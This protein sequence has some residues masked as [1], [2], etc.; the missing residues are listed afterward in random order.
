FDARLATRANVAYLNDRFG[1]FNHDLELAL[2]A[3][4][5]GEGRVGRLV[6]RA[7]KKSFWDGSVYWSLP[8]ETREYV[9]MVLA[10]A[11]LFLHPEDYGLEFPRLETAPGSVVL[12]RE[13]TINALAIC[14]GNAGRRDGWFR[15]LRNLNPRYMPDTVLPAGSSLQA[16]EA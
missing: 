3:Y 13:T 16:P 12:A 8:P 15:A 11:W 9:P 1:E 5:G 7:P 2:A 6:A 14:I 4:N 10:A